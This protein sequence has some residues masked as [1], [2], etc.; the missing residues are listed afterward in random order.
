MRQFSGSEMVTLELAE[1]FGAAGARVTVVTHQHGGLIS[2]LLLAAGDVRLWSSADEGLDAYLRANPP[3]L[4][5]LQHQIVPDA[6]LSG[7]LDAH[8]VFNHMSS[9]EPLERALVPGVERALATASVFNS[10]ETRDRQRES[11]AFDCFEP[12]RLRL[13]ANP[14]PDAMANV[15]RRDRGDGPL[16]L[17]LISNH[18]PKELSQA[19]ALLPPD[20]EVVMIGRQA[21]AGASPARVSAALLAEVDGV[22]SIGKSVQYAI[23]AGLPVYCYDR[24]GG[25][26]WLDLDNLTVARHHNLSGRGFDRK[27]ADAI[28]RELV[29]GYVAA[30]ASVDALRAACGD[31]LLLGP[32]LDDLWEF[33]QTNPRTRSAPDTAAQAAQ[34]GMA[35]L[36]RQWAVLQ[37]RDHDAAAVSGELSALRKEHTRMIVEHGTEV[38]GYVRELSALRDQAA[39]AT[40][41]HGTEVAGYIKE[42][43]A[44]RDEA[45]RAT[46]EHAAEVG[47]YLDELAA[48][49]TCQAQVAEHQRKKI[50]RLEERLERTSRNLRRLEKSRNRKI[51]RAALMLERG[52]DAIARR[53]R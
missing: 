46:A 16:R 10:A 49:R 43:S 37:A 7:A 25:P 1:H 39:R 47:G 13:F 30:S 11:G 52:V 53:V 36:G 27:D 51:M 19:V 34:R 38:A 2:E 41:D 14:A 33:C 31:E 17:L 8:V 22:V 12:D 35:A 40:V 42:L 23:A 5:W 24:F 20:V 50:E 9:Y 44:V 21:G 45:T 15:E 32:S 28:A 6:V 29:D 18:I 48:L 3:D 4:V 26:G